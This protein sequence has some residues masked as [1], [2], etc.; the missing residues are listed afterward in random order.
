MKL[1]SPLW[2]PIWMKPGCPSSIHKPKRS[3]H[4]GTAQTHLHQKVGFRV[5][6]SPISRWWIIFWDACGSKRDKGYSWNL[7]RGVGKTVS[8]SYA[9][10]TSETCTSSHGIQSGCSDAQIQRTVHCTDSASTILTE[11]VTQWL[12]VILRWKTHIV[13]VTYSPD[14]GRHQWFIN[15]FYIPLKKALLQPSPQDGQSGV[16][17]IALPRYYVKV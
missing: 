4:S 1:W 15:W 13:V 12:L 14:Q 11:P 6:A 7:L 10:E 9:E 17:C 3:W 16:K 8:F 5:Q 2:W